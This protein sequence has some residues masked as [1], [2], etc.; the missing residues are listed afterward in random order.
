MKSNPEIIEQYLNHISAMEFPCIG[1]RASAIKGRADIMV[2]DNICC[3]NDDIDILHFLYRFID[4]LRNDKNLYTSASVLFRGPK[5]LTEEEFDRFLWLRL[6]SLSDFDASAFGFAKG[7]S[8][9]PKSSEF[10]YSLK[11]EPFFV[12]ALHAGSSRESRKFEYPVLVF[13][14]HVQFE[15]LRKSGAYV[16]M[17]DIIRNR[18]VDYSGSVNPMLTDFGERSAA[19]QFSG[20]RYESNWKCPFIPNYEKNEH[21]R[22]T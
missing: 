21:N 16:K 4:N 9:D 6:Q 13:N 12:L 10:C 2:A 19:Y 22:T 18:D 5:H 11:E 8:N 20:R 7:V 14:P 15:M 1:A 17:K 3:P